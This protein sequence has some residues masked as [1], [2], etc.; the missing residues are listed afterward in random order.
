M[1]FFFRLP[2]WAF[3]PLMANTR[4]N[5]QTRPIWFLWPNCRRWT[6][7]RL[8]RTLRER[9]G[10]R[11]CR[12]LFLRWSFVRLFCEKNIKQNK[13][14]KMEGCVFWFSLLCFVCVF[15]CGGKRT[16]GYGIHHTRFILL[17]SRSQ[18][19][20]IIPTK[21][22]PSKPNPTHIQKKKNASNSPNDL[23][24]PGMAIP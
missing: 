1:I 24:H 2:F 14:H 20:N 10:R 15:F 19:M 3:P 16:F 11:E 21:Q 22:D 12:R 17:S 6:R 13:K 8:G 23:Y 18:M 5:K 7:P 9:F 4:S